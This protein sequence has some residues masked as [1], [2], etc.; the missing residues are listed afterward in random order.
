[1]YQFDR[2]GTITT[3]FAFLSVIAPIA[4]SQSTGSAGTIEGVALDSSGKPSPETLVFAIRMSPN[5]WTSRP[6]LTTTVGAFALSGLAPGDYVL[7]AAADPYYAPFLSAKGSSN[8]EWSV[9]FLARRQGSGGTTWTNAMGCVSNRGGTQTCLWLNQEDRD[10]FLAS[11]AVSDR[12]SSPLLADYW[13]SYLTASPS[14]PAQLQQNAVYFSSGTDNPVG[15][16][17]ESNVDPSQWRLISACPTGCVGAGDYIGTA[18]NRN[19]GFLTPV[20]RATVISQGLSIKVGDIYSAIA[21][22]PP[23]E[24]FGSNFYPKV[25]W[26]PHGARLTD[27]GGANR[28]LRPWEQGVDIR[29]RHQ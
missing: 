21:V 1:M 20:V 2:F 28:A 29:R 23:G 9:A 11:T 6:V 24:V 14:G 10:Q 26:V 19:M 3:V 18:A 27:F 7:C 25:G 5:R 12:Q 15:A 4:T 8:G 16:V 22:D 17:L 13:F